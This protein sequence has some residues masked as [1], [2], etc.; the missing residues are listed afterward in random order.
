M[1]SQWSTPDG[2]SAKR[3]K[4]YDAQLLKLQQV[5]LAELA[6]ELYGLACAGELT[7]A[8]A[9]LKEAK[10]LLR[11]AQTKLEAKLAELE[12]GQ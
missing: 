5:N 12:S 4:E 9:E 10:N 11:R 1:T 8:H 6:E 3:K 2:Y 7:F